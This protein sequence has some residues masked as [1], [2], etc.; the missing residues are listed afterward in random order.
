MR[1]ICHVYFDALGASDTDYLHDPE[2]VG[3]YNVAPG[4]NVLLLNERDGELKHDPVF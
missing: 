2:P 4:T 3:R 1:T